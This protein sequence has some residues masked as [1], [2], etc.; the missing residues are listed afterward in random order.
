[1]AGLLTPAAL[2]EDTDAATVDGFT[3]T[4]DGTLQAGQESTLT[5]TVTPRR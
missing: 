4:L 3:V 5:F 2:G 1:V